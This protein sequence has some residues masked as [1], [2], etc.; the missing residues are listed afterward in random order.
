[1]ES[2]R[3]SSS[4]LCHSL[5]ESVTAGQSKRGDFPLM[6]SK[7]ALLVIDVQDY[8]SNP[9]TI[10]EEQDYFHT[11]ALPRIIN[12][13]QK[14]LS[15][16][17]EMRDSQEQGCEVI[18]TFLEA[19]TNDCRD[20]SLDYKLSGPRLS[21]LPNSA[22]SSALFLS[23][24]MP[25]TKDGKG[26]ILVP[27]TSC[28][29]FVSTNLHYLL[30]NLHVEQLIVTGQLTDQCVESAVR[31]AADFGY[32]VTVIED[33]CAAISMSSHQKGLYGMKGF[34]RILSTSEVMEELMNSP[35][36]VFARMMP[37]EHTQ[38]SALLEPEGVEQCCNETQSSLA[39]LPVTSPLDIL[40]SPNDLV[41]S[42]LTAL[43][44]GGIKF[45][46]FMA[47]DAY[48]SIRCKVI[49]LDQCEAGT[50]VA[51]AKV[52]FAGLPPFGDVVLPDTG[53]D[54]KGVLIVSPDYGTLRI[55]PYANKTAVV[56][57]TA[58]DV[59]SRQL[60]NICTRGL[61]SRVLETAKTNHGITFN[62]GAE[63][64]FT[65]FSI[66]TRRPV[67]NSV[68]ANSTTL[69]QQEAFIADCYDQL[70]QQAIEI[71]Q[72]H[73]ESGP[74]QLELVIKYQTNPLLLVD[75]VVLARETICQVARKHD[76]IATFL[77]KTFVDKAGSGLHL[78]LSFGQTR[79]P[80]AFPCPSS[81]LSISRDGQSFMEGI[82]R[83]L[84]GLLA[85]SLGSSNSFRRVGP[86][87]WTGHQVAWSIEDKEVP[88]R[89][90]MDVTNGTLTN[91]EFKL[92]D[93]TSNL[94]LSLACILGSGLEGIVKQVKLRPSLNDSS[95]VST[96]G[97][98][99]SFCKALSCLEE[100]SFL[101]DTI[102]GRDLSRAYLAVRRAEVVHASHNTIEQEVAEA[103]L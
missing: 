80:N 29:V 40:N 51:I 54:A 43:K 72:L 24:L 83:H 41:N 1:M 99:N 95:P 59:P 82:L 98:P 73:A 65:L 31:D 84:K 79:T 6:R 75:Q 21:S 3:V 42:M 70:R 89:V 67:D 11:T 53:L 101:T 38:H 47:V 15:I 76:C 74:G 91:V 30:Q 35:K 57:G 33:A 23:D 17:R 16:F 36:E 92:S 78:H 103:L 48:N 85:I 27:K 4:K 5:A 60:S 49:P 46:R 77:P 68:F 63:L 22:T 7:A 14:L 19:R 37:F 71:E 93:S 26:D 69:N 39:I 13:L 45:I 88:L 61:L 25:R 8:L 102:M 32:F 34:C 66:A 87:C 97:L 44:F 100:D 28:S 56:F 62:V 10:Q 50:T 52:C 96:E 2:S 81:P 12:N 64:E 18:F 9:S 20:V 58:H 94:Y 90:C 55:L 86:G